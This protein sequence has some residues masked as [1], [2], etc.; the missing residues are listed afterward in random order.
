[1]AFDM[2][3]HTF[4]PKTGLQ[5]DKETG[6]LVGIEPKPIKA[7]AGSDYPKWVVP[8]DSLVVRNG[9]HVTVPLFPEMFVDREGRVT[10]LVKDGDEEERATS[11]AV[12]VA[13]DAA[14]KEPVKAL[15][16]EE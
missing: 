8:H 6:H 14:S 13:D 1:M 12:F 9:E 3:K 5:V 11:Q 16:H 10:V 7:E 15:Q 4:D 2:D